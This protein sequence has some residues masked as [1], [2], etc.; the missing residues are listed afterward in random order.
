MNN[1]SFCTK[2]QP[3]KEAELTCAKIK[4]KNGAVMAG[5]KVAKTGELLKSGCQ[6]GMG[7]MYLKH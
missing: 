1:I 6:E 2:V 5:W 3:L 7:I 4:L